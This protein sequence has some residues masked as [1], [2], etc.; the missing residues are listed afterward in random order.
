MGKILGSNGIMEK[1]VDRYSW[2]EEIYGFNYSSS[3][4]DNVTL[5]LGRLRGNRDYVFRYFCVNLIGG[6]SNGQTL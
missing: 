3:P 4:N 2:S 1:V 6:V 5:L